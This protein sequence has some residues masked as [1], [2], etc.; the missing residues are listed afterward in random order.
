MLFCPCRAQKTFLRWGVARQRA[1]LTET[2]AWCIPCLKKPKTSPFPTTIKYS[3]LIMYKITLG[4]FGIRLTSLETKET[5]YRAKRTLLLKFPPAAPPTFSLFHILASPSWPRS[6]VCSPPGRMEY[7]SQIK[8]SPF[9]EG[10]EHSHGELLVFGNKCSSSL[11]SLYVPRM[12]KSCEQYT[13]TYTHIHIHTHT[14]VNTH[15]CAH[16]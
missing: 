11:A 6:H 8:I 12:C 13:Y 15:S 16:A 14:Y 1:H 2:G 9:L 10:L 4:H 3:F 5:Y 7:P